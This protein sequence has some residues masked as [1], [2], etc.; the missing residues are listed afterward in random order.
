LGK[1]IEAD[2]SKADEFHGTESQKESP[3]KLR[4]KVIWNKKRK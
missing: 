1:K 3:R 4:R 2:T